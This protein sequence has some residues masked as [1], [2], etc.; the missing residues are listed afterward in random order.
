MRMLHSLKIVAWYASNLLDPQSAVKRAEGAAWPEPK[1]R[2]KQ[3]GRVHFW[4]PA[5]ST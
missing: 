5:P 3:K 4:N 1:D 2:L